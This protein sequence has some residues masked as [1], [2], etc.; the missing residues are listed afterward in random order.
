MTSS[1]PALASLLVVATGVAIGSWSDAPR[2][3]PPR[4]LFGLGHRSLPALLAQ[5]GFEVLSI[6]TWSLEQNPY[7]FMQSLLNAVGFERDR[8]YNTLKGQPRSLA[9]KTM[10]L[11]LLALLVGPGLVWSS[12]LSLLGRGSTMTVIARR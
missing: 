2:L 1:F 8:A 12:V 5:S 11:L 9:G 10:D 6:D 3:D 4:H 7:G